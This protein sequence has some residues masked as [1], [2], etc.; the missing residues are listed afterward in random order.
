MPNATPSLDTVFCEAIEIADPDARAVY[1]ARA[2]GADVGLR[3]RV[4]ALIA[5]HFRAESFLDRPA[6]AAAAAFAPGNDPAAAPEPGSVIGP[7]TLTEKVGEGG[8]GAVYVADQAAPVKRRVA[9]KVIKPGMDTTEVVARFEAER[10]AL[11]LMDHPNIATVLDAGST[12]QGRP[13]FVMELVRGLPITEYC[14]QAVLPADRRLRLFARVC[15]AV[16]HA[17]QKGVIHRDLKPTNVLVTEHD[18]Q[19]VPKVIDFGVAKAVNQRLTDRTVHTRLAQLVGTPMYM[20]PEQA[21][22]GGLDVDTRADVY[23]LGVLLYELLTGTTPFD[24]EALRRAGFDELRRV[25]REDEPPRPSQ[26]VSTLD[27]AARSTVSARRGL[28]E[29]RLCRLLRG[30]LDRVVM[31]A[32]EKDR[33]RRYESA[34]AFAVD[35]ER[36]L[37]GRPVEAR[38][39]S[40]AYRLRKYALRNKAAVAMAAVLFAAGLAVAVTVGWTARARS[41]ERAEAGRRAGEFLGDADRL[42]PSGRWVEALA[43][44]ERAEAVLGPAGDAGLRDRVRQRKRVLALVLRAEAI[45]LDFATVREED[46]NSELADRRFAE[47]FREYGLDIDTVSPGEAAE[48]LPDG[49]AQGEVVA[50][51]DEWA[52][53]RRDHSDGDDRGWKHL[54]ATARAADTDPWR[55]RVRALWQE[56]PFHRPSR[57]IESLDEWRKRIVAAGWDRDAYVANLKEVLK[58]APLDRVHPGTAQ[59]LAQMANEHPAVEAMLREAQ[60]RRPGDLWLNR[61]LAD[62]LARTNPREAVSFIRAALALRPESPV[63]LSNLGQALNDS[64]QFDEALAT[65]DRA[66]RLRP[67]YATAHLNRGVA[68]AGKGLHVE[69]ATEYREAIRLRPGLREA[70]SNLGNALYHQGRFGEAAAAYREATR[71]R[72]GDV[73]ALVSLGHALGMSGAADEAVAAYREAIR[74]RPNNAQVLSTLGTALLALKRDYD[75]AAEAYRRAI[76]LQ[77]NAQVHHLNLGSAMAQK[78]AIDPAIA[79]YREAVR[80]K[81]DDVVA[82]KALAGQLVRKRAWGEVVVI[83]RELV[84]LQPE[85]AEFRYALGDTLAAKGDLD[86]AVTALREAIRLKPDEAGWHNKLCGL[87]YRKRAWADAAAAAREAIRLKPDFA[88]AHCNL[89]QV[90]REQGRYREALAALRRGHELGS[91]YP[92][93]RFPSARWV[94]ECEALAVAAEKN[95]TP[96]PREVAPLPRPRN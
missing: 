77:P 17:H 50:A 38:P 93:W 34:G 74:L 95:G 25:I 78:G 18:G 91:R 33:D 52:F 62:E 55:D 10:Q 32:L 37:A 35:V 54:V 45:R 65:F 51:L 41:A 58:T 76:D 19:P 67:D 31:K 1:L 12:D 92:G 9:L 79:A 28:D 80:L 86:E 84:R 56:T 70:H 13:Y 24:P 15:R 44:V 69:A 5:A 8:M 89:G 3:C 68:L 43:L 82:R 61:A 46:L 26:R 53:A 42:E 2:C 47:A 4:E 20:A 64:G 39:P 63:L 66:L 81:P 96:A 49:A 40:A 22:L 59:Y 83:V 29:R 11:A 21:E 94:R 7:Y 48:R 71:L 60:R 88:E 30:D 90:L 6:E 23:S 73:D 27:A 75:G 72:P 16:Q 87:F 14:D 57:S 85:N 36:Y